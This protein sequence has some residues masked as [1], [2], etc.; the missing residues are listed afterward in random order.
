MLLNQHKELARDIIKKAGQKKA[1]TAVVSIQYKTE[2]EVSVREQRIET[3]SQSNSKNLSLTLSVNQ[4]KSTVSSTDFSPKAIDRLV[5]DAIQLASISGKD[6]FYCLPDPSELGKTDADLDMFDAEEGRIPTEKRIAMAKEMESKMLAMDKELISDGASVSSY[7]GHSILANSLG[8]CEGYPFS[9]SYLGVSC[10]VPDKGEGEN[11]E[12]KQSGYWYD[13]DIHFSK[14]ESIDKIA[15][16]AAKRTLEKRGARKPK[17]QT[18]P[19]IFE[20]QVAARFL[21]LIANAISGRSIYTKQSYLVDQLNRKIAGDNITIYDNPLIPGQIGSKLYDQEGVKV[22][23][24]VVVEKGVLKTY[25]LDV[26]S[27]KKLNLKTTGNAGG[28]GNFYLEKGQYSL[29]ELIASIENGVL[30]TSLSGF[31]ANIQNGDYSQGAQGFWIEKGK[32]AY[33]VNEF[34]IASTIPTMLSTVEMIANDPLIRGS[35]YSPSIKIK[36]MTISGA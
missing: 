24:K 25:L 3:L 4:K 15:E 18:V 16:K 28:T 9:Y 6:D 8:F 33:P 35:I 19:V 29:D 32:I 20:N 22:S 2:N 26:Y 36:E 27:A 7:S 34:T 30:I 13:Y 5:E 1:D 14:L 10:A 17:T 21:S 11:T 31:G 12:R 23:S